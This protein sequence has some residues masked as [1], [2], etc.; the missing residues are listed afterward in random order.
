MTES[1]RLYGLVAQFTAP[2]AL[3]KAAA[4]ARA[5]GYRGLDAYAP[6]P[7]HGLSEALGLKP[8]HLP[9]VTL[10]GGLCGLA[11]G[12]LMQSWMSATDHPVDLGERAVASWPSFI[13]IAILLAILFASIA[14]VIGMLLCSRLPELHHP[15]FSAPH[16]ERASADR[17]FLCIEATGPHFDRA[18]VRRFLADMGAEEI[19]DVAP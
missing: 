3:V 2:D 1:P 4:R 5:A 9:W 16:F 19:S 14:T 13:P 15:I 11:T 7:V 8:S 10:L 18:T 6:M 12:L 17:F